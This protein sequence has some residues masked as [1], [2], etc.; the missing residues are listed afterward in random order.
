MAAPGP[1][2]FGPEDQAAGDPVRTAVSM[3]RI[4][5]RENNQP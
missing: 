3:L 5:M 1:D 4:K 2:M